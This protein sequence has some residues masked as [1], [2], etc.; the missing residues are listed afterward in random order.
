MKSVVPLALLIAA[1]GAWSQ[2]GANTKASD[3]LSFPSGE[4]RITFIGHGTLMLD[5]KGWI[6]HVDP[7][8]R[9]A[10][11]TKLPKADLILITHEHADH[12]DPK[13]VA[14]IRQAG[15]RIVAN[16]A[17]AKALSGAE[18]L[19]NG[20]AITINGVN[21]LAIAAYNTTPGREHFHP[22]GRGNGYVL[23]FA[24]QRVYIAGDTEVTREM[25]GLKDIAVAFLPMNQPYTM[26][27]EQVA[28]AARALRPRILYPYHYGETDPA[29]LPALLKDLPEVE[30]R[31]RDLR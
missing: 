20:E 27:P 14:Q 10:D 19:H 9:E 29:R 23:D 17:A 18:V 30:V 28:E 5:W 15:T 25:L 31:I 1:S 12:L 2:T 13:A 4:L 24:G 3:V 26:T 16:E 11:Y 6:I 21:I 8:S 22:R 7:V